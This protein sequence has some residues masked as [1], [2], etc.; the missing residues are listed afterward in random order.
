MAFIFR[1]H[2]D[3]FLGL[4]GMLFLG[5]M[6]LLLA[7][8][9]ISGVVLYAPFM[10]QLAFGILRR[11]KSPRVKWLDYLATMAACF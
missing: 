8:S 6:G 10:R 3:L 1:L 7:V 2:T 4:P 11:D 5:F 9:I